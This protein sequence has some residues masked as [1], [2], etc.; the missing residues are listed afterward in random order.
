[1]PETATENLGRAITRL[2]LEDKFL[3]NGQLQDYPLAQ[4]AELANQII[5]EKLR[6]GR[7]PTV[8][9]MMWGGLGK[10]DVLYEGDKN[11]LRQQIL[12]SVRQHLPLGSPD[13]IKT[14]AQ[15]GENDFLFRMA[16]EIPELSYSDFIST[17]NS[18][19]H[20]Y[21]EDPQNTDKR[22]TIHQIAA[23][24]AMGERRY[25]NAFYHFRRTGNTQAIDGLFETLFEQVGE[26]RDYVHLLEQIASDDWQ[27]TGERIKKLLLAFTSG[28][29][30]I[31]A[32]HAFE[33]FDHY[34]TQFSD[35]ERKAFYN[36]VAQNLGRHN[37]KLGF[38]REDRGISDKQVHLLW[39]KKHA[40]SEPTTS[41]GIFTEQKYDGKELRTALIKGL[42]S[43]HQ[44]ERLLT[45]QVEPEHLR[46]VYDEMPFE[47]QAQISRQLEDKTELARL[48][49]VAEAKG[50]LRIAY[51]LWVDSENGF[52][53]EYMD[54]LRARLIQAE[55][56]D[57]LKRNLGGPSFY[58]LD[59]QDRKGQNDAFNAVMRTGAGENRQDFLESAFN[60]A[61]SQGDQAMLERV[62]P[63]MVA[64]NLKWALGQF[65]GDWYRE[66]RMT[67]PAGFEYALGILAEREGIGKDQLRPIVARYGI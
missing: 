54:G 11:Q 30:R 59:K 24:K 27:K 21:L 7:W 23:E 5:A 15:K 39:A 40:E 33:L 44:N 36:V 20:T 6:L 17:I 34:R 45:S 16:T 41:Y 25:G 12:D 60:I 58:F 37:L 38:S 42:K 13:A 67:D 65:R 46:M 22:N 57:H 62:R 2:G 55:V 56:E 35:K 49:R 14:L 9:Q 19:P 48:S 3:Q 51:N 32:D 50:E 29:I 43:P 18:M 31:D 26:N 53:G 63:Q 1:M 47:L 66:G 10:A 28:K 52:E 64:T 61:L 8:V 4:R